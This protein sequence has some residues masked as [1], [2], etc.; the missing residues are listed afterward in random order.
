MVALP[1]TQEPSA[2]LFYFIF[3]LEVSTA[4]N[5]LFTLFHI[6]CLPPPTVFLGFPYSSAGKESACDV[7]D[8]DSIPGEG[9]GYPLQNSGLENSMD[10]IVHGVAKSQTWLSDFNFPPT[11]LWIRSLFLL[12]I[13]TVGNAWPIVNTQQISDDWME[14]LF[15]VFIEQ[16]I[17]YHAL[18]AG[19]EDALLISVLARV[20]EE[21]SK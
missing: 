2:P 20:V 17:I 15:H 12:T 6:Q 3:L 9:K 13:V 8:L 18:C 19:P 5:H 1:P 14:H 21:T 11:P 10:C 16:T 4:S 7:R